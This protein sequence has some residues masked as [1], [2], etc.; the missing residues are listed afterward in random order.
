M[1]KAFRHAFMA[2]AL[3]AVLAGSFAASSPAMAVIK[4]DR[5]K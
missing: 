5:K 4:F 3:V 2:F 1:K